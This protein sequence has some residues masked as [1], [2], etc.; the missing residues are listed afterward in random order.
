MLAQ[1]EATEVGQAFL[2][3]IFLS[4]ERGGRQDCLPHSSIRARADKADGLRRP[5]PPPQLFGQKRLVEDLFEG[6]WACG[7]Q[8]FDQHAGPDRSRLASTRVGIAK[9]GWHRPSQ[10]G[11]VVENFRDLF[12]LLE[13]RALPGSPYR[14]TDGSCR[15]T[16]IKRGGTALP[17]CISGAANRRRHL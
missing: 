6:I 13:D 8:V 3:A 1:L 15:E 2:P 11:R 7:R 4:P 9:A 16:T 14:S 5:R 17:S 10:A 12:S